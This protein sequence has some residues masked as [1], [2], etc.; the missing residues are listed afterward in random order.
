M[1]IEIPPHEVVAM[2]HAMGMRTRDEELQRQERKRQRVKELVNHL[3][4]APGPKK[5]KK[6]FKPRKRPK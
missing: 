2:A 1:P 6:K 4:N 5:A 3:R